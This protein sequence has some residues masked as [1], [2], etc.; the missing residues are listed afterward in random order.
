LI[1][2]IYPSFVT[3]FDLREQVASNGRA[4]PGGRY[5]AAGD[6]QSIHYVLD[7]YS[8]VYAIVTI[9]NY[10]PRVAFAAL[11]ELK[12][13]FQAEFGSRMATSGE[14]SLTKASTPLLKEFVQ[15]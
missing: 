2:F 13:S 7:Q 6:T 12:D 11:E 8:K 1:T 5:T 9:P 14:G 4:K 3:T 10:S 15:K